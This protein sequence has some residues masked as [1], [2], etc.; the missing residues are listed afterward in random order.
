MGIRQVRRAKLNLESKERL[1]RKRDFRD[2][3]IERSADVGVEGAFRGRRGSRSRFSS[4]CQGPSTCR[5][6]FL[7]QLSYEGTP[8]PCKQRPALLSI[9]TTAQAIE[10]AYELPAHETGPETRMYRETAVVP[11]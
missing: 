10:N 9:C 5:S 4:I 6:L 7:G 3:P 2:E 1:A 11:L 8:V